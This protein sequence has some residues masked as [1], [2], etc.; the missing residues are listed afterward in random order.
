MKEVADTEREDRL[1]VQDF[2]WV[3]LSFWPLFG[4]LIMAFGFL[5]LGI[6]WSMGFVLI[7]QEPK[8]QTTDEMYG[9]LAVEASP[10][11]PTE[12]PLPH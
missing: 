6:A 8:D 9:P 7:W 12:P 11:T 2:F 5:L 4:L 3:Q 10:V 1:V